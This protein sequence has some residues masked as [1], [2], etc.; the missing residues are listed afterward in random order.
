MKISIEM[1]SICQGKMKGEMNKKIQAINCSK[2]TR[3]KEKNMKK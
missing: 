1:K 2:N 3:G